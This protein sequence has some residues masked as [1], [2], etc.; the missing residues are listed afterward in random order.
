MY[1]SLIDLAAEILGILNENL[2]VP[3]A[4]NNILA[5]IKR[6]TGFDAVG[7]RLRSGEDFP[8]FIQDG[9][10]QNFLL[11][12]NTLIARN[13]RG[14][15][16]RDENGAISLE[17]TCGVVITGQTDPTNPFFTLGGSFWTNDSRPLLDRAPDQTLGLH[18]RNICF[19]Q[20][21][22]SMALIPIRAN[23][24]IVGLLQLTD[25]KKD[26]FTLEMV[27]ILEGISNSIGA[28]LK[29]KQVDDAL[30]G[31]EQRY[32]LLI[33]TAREGIVVVQGE[34][35]KFVNPIM[36]E[37]TGYTN[38]E[39][40]SLPF[41]EFIHPDDIELVKTNYRNRQ[42]GDV[43]VPRYQI[44][45]LKKDKHITWV[46]VSGVRTEWEGHPATINFLTDITERKQAEEDLRQIEARLRQSEK[47]EAIGTLA[48][49]IAHDFNNVLGGIIGYTDMSLDLVEKDSVLEKNLRKVLTASDRAKQLVQQILTFSR[50]GK[51]KKSV[52]P[53]RPIIK[54]VLELLKAS[55]PSSVIIKSELGENSKPVLADPTKIHEMLL[56]LST[57]A[58]YA[59]KRRGTLTVRLYDATLEHELYGQEG[60]IP[61][62]EY[63]VIEISDTGC[64]IDSQTITKI[65]NPFFTTKPV[66]EGTGMGLSV[67]LGVVQLHG[68]GLQ[69]ESEPGKGSTFR[70]FLP[71][72]GELES[73]IAGDDAAVCRGGT[74]RILFVDDE[75]VL[76]EIAKENFSTLGYTVT[77]M[78]DSVEALKFI[79]A[80]TA[81]IDLIITDQTMPGMT[82]MEL[83]KAAL[84]IRK[85]IPIILC[86]GYSSEATTESVA[87]IGISRFVKKP[88]LR[89]E[90]AG[91]VR[92]VLDNYSKEEAHGANISN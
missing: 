83:A 62:G 7:I 60:K 91:I 68:G 92:G 27:H 1:R 25:R 50:Q 41:L 23:R 15:L 19:R 84:K 24:E 53:L 38:E 82:G 76:V 46:E 14:G 61:P 22:L 78:A 57:N 12:E 34:R 52:I 45:F 26:C 4:I 48:G 63:E 35:F 73:E 6:A 70:I 87:A 3:E 18:S 64:G 40:L 47:M 81:A 43:A 80:N 36:L 11:T 69:V 86:T 66:G 90:F 85:D 54:E 42:K 72:T 30:H 9:F 13:E 31:S 75:K 88:L 5:A 74:E 2:G 20:G 8:Y 29:R 10:S 71:I 65:F 51:S 37:Q 33:E 67:V 16:C 49:G 77:G 32:R 58:V 79:K 39:L 28:A 89:R 21:F 55:I 44:R 56:N 17:C 59:M